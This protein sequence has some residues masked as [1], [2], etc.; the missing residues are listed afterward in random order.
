VKRYLKGVST[1]K[2]CII[3][4][5]I[6]VP[7]KS[8]YRKKDIGQDRLITAYAAKLIYGKPVLII[9]FGT[10]V[11]FDMVSVNNVYM[12]GLILPGIKMSLRSLHRDTA[13]LPEISLRQAKGFI[14]NNTADSIRNGIIYGYASIC[15]GLINRFKKRYKKLKIITT[16]GNVDLIALHTP[17]I[18]TIDKNLSL[19]G[20]EM[21]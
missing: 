7:I 9:D 1:R 10:A 4:K 14:A 18:K 6:T 5:D 2:I 20:L 17:S 8:L 21:I 3:G 12:G 19:K 11:T 13:L 15:E 16:G